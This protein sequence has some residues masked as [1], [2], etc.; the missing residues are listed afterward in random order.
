MN[1]SMVS[2]VTQGV[3]VRI[4][5]LHWRKDSTAQAEREHRCKSR[6]ICNG[7]MWAQVM[8]WA[9]LASNRL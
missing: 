8:P 3:K 2:G 7:R 1:D 9:A 6:L 4:Q 5:R